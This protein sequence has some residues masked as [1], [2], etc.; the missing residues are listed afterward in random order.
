MLFVHRISSEQ[1]RQEL[2]RRVRDY[3]MTLCP[4]AAMYHLSPSAYMPSKL[5]GSQVH[6][7]SSTHVAISDQES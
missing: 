3:E 4:P 6:A 5:P 1:D 7:S 2:L